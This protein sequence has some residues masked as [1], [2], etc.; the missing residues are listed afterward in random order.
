MQIITVVDLEW[1]I[2]KNKPV[3]YTRVFV[4]F[5]NW[6]NR[7]Q[8]YKINAMIKLKKIRALTAENLC[9]FGVYWI[10]KI[11]P[12]LRSTHVVFKNQNKF[13]FFVNNYIN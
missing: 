10:I 12:V 9:N 6:K 1:F 5:Y 13:V 3:I 4:E 11:L 8:V 2:F 7:R